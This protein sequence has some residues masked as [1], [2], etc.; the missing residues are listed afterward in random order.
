[1]RLR[2]RLQHFLAAVVDQIC[3]PAAHTRDGVAR[4]HV[5]IPADAIGAALVVAAL[6]ARPALCANPTRIDVD[7]PGSMLQHIRRHSLFTERL[8]GQYARFPCGL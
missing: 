3:G 4:L 1:M 6:F 7:R 2:K 8:A 5:Q